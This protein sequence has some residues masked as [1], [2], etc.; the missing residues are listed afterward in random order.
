MA[1]HLSNPDGW[2]MDARRWIGWRML[3]SYAPSMHRRNWG[4]ANSN[5]LG[6]WN[7]LELAFGGY[8]SDAKYFL[9]IFYAY[10]RTILIKPIARSSVNIARTN[11]AGMRWF[12]SPVYPP[13]PPKFNE[14]VKEL[15][16][17]RFRSAWPPRKNVAW[18]MS[19]PFL[20]LRYGTIISGF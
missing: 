4:E 3:A 10:S 7:Y 5:C 15:T 6:T 18:N 2:Y 9:R 17:Y 1:N 20:L 11:K 8:S 12:Q 14:W 16:R 13:S 19:L